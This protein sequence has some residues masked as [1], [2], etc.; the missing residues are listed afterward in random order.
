[1][2]EGQLRNFP[3]DVYDTWKHTRATW[4]DV[5]PYSAYIKENSYTG[6]MVGCFFYPMDRGAW[7][8][9]RDVRE[10]EIGGP[11]EERY[12]A[13]QNRLNEILH[14]VIIGTYFIK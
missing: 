7:R 3:F 1:M 13:M 2:K 8:K 11:E 5:G 4:V 10:I 12:I 6:A 14:E 9:T